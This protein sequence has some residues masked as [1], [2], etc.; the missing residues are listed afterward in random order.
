[1]GREY[2]FPDPD[3]QKKKVEL[4]ES[5]MAQDTPKERQTI[6]MAYLMDTS[7]PRPVIHQ[8]MKECGL[9][10]DFTFKEGHDGLPGVEDQDS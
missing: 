9:K 6:F 2:T 4:K 3:H 7:Y 1:M 10:N 5:L 8:A